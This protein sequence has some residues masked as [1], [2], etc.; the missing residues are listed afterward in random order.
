M[1]RSLSSPIAAPRLETQFFTLEN[2]LELLVH[3]DWSAPVA[4]I[5]AW[6][7]TGSIHEERLLGSGVSHLVEHLLFKGTERHSGGEF[8]RKIQN[9][10]GYVN[11]YTSFDRTVYWVDLPSK[12]VATTLDLLADAV[13]RST[14]PAEEFAKE[15]DV[16]RREFAMGFDDPDRL[17]SEQ[18]FATAYQVHPYRLPVIG[19]L[20][21]FDALS[22]EDALG[23][24]EER[25]AP[26]NVFF[27][28]TGAVRASE[29][30]EQLSQAVATV[31]RLALP[32]VWVPGEPTQMAPRKVHTEFDTELTRMS[33]AWHVPH[34]KHEDVPALDLLAALLGEGRTA[35]LYRSLRERKGLVHSVG[36]WTYCPSDT[37]VF[38]VSAVLDPDRRPQVEAALLEELDAMQQDLVRS[39]DLERICRMRFSSYL[40]ALSTARGRASD[41]GDSWMACRNSDFSRL[42]GEMLAKVQPEDV[43]R[44]AQIYLKP[45]GINVVS[46]NPKG[47]A[48]AVSIG[49]TE[50]MRGPIEK[51][52]LGNGLR[53]LLCRDA[54]LPLVSVN[55]GFKAG[56]LVETS[57]NN[58]IS[59]LL[60]RVLLKGT[61][62][63]S[64]EDIA[65]TLESLGGGIG[66]DA[67]KGTISVGVTVLRDDLEL[68]LEILADVVCHA[69][70]PPEALERER[71]VQL[72][73]I[74]SEREDPFTVAGQLLR[75]HLLPGHPDGFPAFGT[76]E[77]VAAVRREDLLAFRD[78]YFVGQNGVLSI[79]GD[80]E[81]QHAASLA[82]RYFGGLRNGTLALTHPVAPEELKN[83]KRVD[84]PLERQQVVLMTG[85]RGPN[86][87]HADQAALSLLDEACSDL[88]SRMFN[89]I[90]EELGL[91]Y[92]VGA[93]HFAG[94]SSGYF[95][96]YLATDPT[97][98]EDALNEL[99]AEIR[100]LATNGLTAEELARAKEK[101][102]GGMELQQ[103]NLASFGASCLADELLGLGA[104]H[105]LEERAAVQAV[106]AEEL[107]T[108]AARI[109]EDK[110]FVT[111][112]V[113]PALAA[114][115]AETTLSTPAS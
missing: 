69:V 78:Q 71:S 75:A 2:G 88:G 56:R 1:P 83:I 82:E 28:V 60:S 114:E 8:A 59:K 17:Q 101:F 15:K 61:A 6:V 104:G 35:R 24:F 57:E 89:R 68:A 45:R 14:L 85:Y 62:T 86:M 76:L 12:G 77:S 115:E 67:G 65:D 91:A 79:F 36:A 41:I 99:L 58:G 106:T 93:S 7:Q 42:Y 72:A 20:Q 9:L 10:G 23:Y 90:R 64:A 13:F 105:H 50:S 107:R 38:G 74:R 39:E 52:V 26:N 53:L 40:G 25:Y 21:V 44:V 81:P 46:L 34:G 55:I 70:F 84:E 51:N 37:G 111:L 80:V 19:H 29:V 92:S 66:A 73:A 108:V 31:P 5:Q 110:P 3:E 95:I 32:P 18:L 94:L 43:R 16:I 100:S 102:L 48:K 33:L 98:R 87:F 96:F 4:S 63:R 49:S 54:R 27:V 22:R 112:V 103:Q 11:A 113:G 109:F 47:H 97:K 30:F